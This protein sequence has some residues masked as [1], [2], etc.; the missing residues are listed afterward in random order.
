MFGGEGNDVAVVAGRI[1][2]VYLGAGDDQSF[3]FG[4]GG[5]IN[6]GTGRDY[7]VTSGNYNRVD[8]GDDQ[9]YSVTIGNNNQVELGAG[10][11]F[12]NVFGNYNRINANTGND[13]IKLMGYHAVLNG[14]EGDDRL[15][16][17]AISKYSQFN[18]GEGRDLMV[19]GGYQN[20]FKGGTGVDSFVV[21]GD[22]IDNLVEDIRSEDKIVF[23]GIDWPK[24]WFERSGYDLTL[25]TL[26]N[27][28]NDTD[29]AKFENIGSVTFSDYFNG[30][31][32]QIVIAMGEKEI[33]GERECTTLSDNAVDALV[34]AMSGFAP[35]VGDNGFIDNLDSK[36]RIAI[37]TA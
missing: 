20:T 13:V 31:R 33:D 26:R 25:S 19:L 24:L 36:S 8:T 37:T 11:D 9:D 1:N 23:N 21:S 3:V 35:Q 12:A 17:A 14:G 16:A 10:N 27:L 2:H 28:E 7:V 32:A 30:N 15:I 22:V 18:G 5:E 6:T 29:Q 4:E 34:Q